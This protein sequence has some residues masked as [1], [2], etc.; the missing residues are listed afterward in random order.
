MEALAIDS[1]QIPIRVPLI[2]DLQPLADA[3]YSVYFGEKNDN[4]EDAG[5]DLASNR[6]TQDHAPGDTE[7][8]EVPGINVDIESRAKVRIKD[9]IGIVGRELREDW[10][11]SDRYGKAIQV[12]AVAGQVLERVRISETVI[13]PTAIHILR[14]TQSPNLASLAV[15]GMVGL[16]Q[17]II[18]HTWVEAMYKTPRMVESVNQNFPG[19]TELAEDIGPSKERHWYSHVREA[20]SSFLTYG[21]TPFVIAER[22][23]KPDIPKSK[24]HLRAAE[25]TGKCALFGLVLTQAVGQAITHGN[26]KVGDVILNILER[27]YVWFGAAMAVEA[28]RFIGKRIQR[29]KAKKHNGIMEKNQ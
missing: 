26:E 25:M 3:L 17:A 10:R 28:P 23:T 11:S 9:R 24:M 18:S 16:S 22:I 6:D 29:Y 21:V 2:E 19:L 27:P 8:G 1:Q 5:A 15:L 7:N 14:E 4:V 13:A 20:Y 12:G